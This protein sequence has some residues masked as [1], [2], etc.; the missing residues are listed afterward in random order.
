MSGSANN[1]GGA[2]SGDFKRAVERLEK[3][4][5]EFAATTGEGISSRAT[6]FVEDAAE[7]LEQE[8]RYRRHG[9]GGRGPRRRHHRRSYTVRTQNGEPYGEPYRTRRLYRDTANEKIC[10]VCA[11]LARYFGMDIWVVRCLAITGL[12]F[13]PSII[14]PAYFIACMLLPK[15]PGGRTRRSK[16]PSGRDAQNARDKDPY[17]SPAPELGA[18]FS[19]RTSLRNVQSDLDQLELKLRRMESHVTSGRYELQRELHQLDS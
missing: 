16:D 6:G 9:R 11:G 18:R 3:A 5:N 1:T 7:R 4:V 14:L 15:S 19:P 13:M 10:G 12:V 8:L 17:A 2:G